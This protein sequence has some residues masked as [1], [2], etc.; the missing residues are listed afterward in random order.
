MSTSARICVTCRSFCPAGTYKEVQEKTNGSRV[1]LEKLKGE[2][3][4][5]PPSID[6]DGYST[7]TTGVWPTVPGDEWCGE[8]APRGAGGAA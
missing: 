7:I 6:A 3:R 1:I 2:C 4:A 5:R 8:W